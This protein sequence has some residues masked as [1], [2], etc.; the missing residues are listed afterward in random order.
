M[1]HKMD[2]KVRN[3]HKDS[4][5]VEDPQGCS[6]RAAAAGRQAGRQISCVWLRTNEQDQ[7]DGEREGEAR[8]RVRTCP[9]AVRRSITTFSVTFGERAR[10]LRVS[11]AYTGRT[12]DA[13]AKSGRRLWPDELTELMSQLPNCFLKGI[14]FGE[15]AKENSGWILGRPGLPSE[16]GSSMKMTHTSSSLLL[17]LHRLEGKKSHKRASPNAFFSNVRSTLT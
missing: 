11:G 8:V 5:G 6:G 10:Y 2:K 14:S 3:N 13:F 15:P 4:A 12:D 16:R 17:L 1:G 9:A 7:L